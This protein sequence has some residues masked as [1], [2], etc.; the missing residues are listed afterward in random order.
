MQ[1]MSMIAA[2]L[3]MA[4][5]ILPC[6]IA[7]TRIRRGTVR[8]HINTLGIN[9]LEP[10]ISLNPV[11][12]RITGYGP[13]GSSF[14]IETSEAS[15]QI[16]GL[17][18]GEWNIIIHAQNETGSLIGYG[19]GPASI[20]AGTAEPVLIP[21]VPIEAGGSFS[22]DVNWSPISPDVP[23]V[24]AELIDGS[25]SSLPFSFAIDSAGAISSIV[26]LDSGYYTLAVR[27]T[28]NGTPVMGAAEV[29]RIMTGTLTTG[30]FDFINVDQ[31]GS[32]TSRSIAPVADNTIELV[33][34]GH[35]PEIKMGSS[36]TLKASSPLETM[37]TVFRW[38]LDGEKLAGGDEIN[39]GA[40][41]D[42]G[43]H[44]VDVTAITTGGKRAGSTT[45]EFRV[46]GGL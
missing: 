15:V 2:L 20:R 35:Q 41:L 24:E 30:R 44:R 10:A 34:T 40:D 26:L 6:Q 1:E 13:G 29:V 16:N 12:F 4:A 27:L 39:L 3:W 28:K 7:F 45:Y 33:I 5:F 38:Y 14:D 31:P 17:L 18:I 23:G 43:Y 42:P 25:G 9:T 37:E 19:S 22:L 8:L 32:S 36:M 21:V 46:K 11:H